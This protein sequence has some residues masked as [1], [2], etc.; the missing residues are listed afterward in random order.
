VRW[1]WGWGWGW[2][3]SVERGGGGGAWSVEVEAER[4]AMPAHASEAIRSCCRL[5]ARGI[6]YCTR[7]HSTHVR[8]RICRPAG[9][10]IARVSNVNR[11]RVVVV[12][13]SVVQSLKQYKISYLI[14]VWVSVGIEQTK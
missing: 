5:S 1:G 8:I 9:A 7:L 14:C 2:R 6:V 3:R 4:L 10:R 13:G 12:H 11:N